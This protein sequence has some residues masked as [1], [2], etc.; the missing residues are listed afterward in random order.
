[1][2]K[3]Q[4]LFILL[5]IFCSFTFTGYSQRRNNTLLKDTHIADIELKLE[6][7]SSSLPNIHIQLKLE[8]Y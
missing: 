4:K 7:E 1:M 6:N 5:L 8:L 3:I 2:K